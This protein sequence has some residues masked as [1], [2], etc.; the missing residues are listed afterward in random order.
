[1]FGIL[2]FS[3]VAALYG[4]LCVMLLTSWRGR[5]LGGFLI[6]ACF[7]STIW[8]LLL[9]ASAAD[10]SVPV[11]AIFVVEV[12]R[13]GA[14]LTFLGALVS[15]IGVSGRIGI[16]AHAVWITVLLAGLALWL[17]SDY[18]GPI[19][20]LGSVLIPGGLVIALVG[21]ILIEQLYRNSAPESR[22]NLI[23]VT[24]VDHVTRDGACFDDGWPADERVD[25]DAALQA[26]NDL[27]ATGR[28]DRFDP[29]AAGSEQSPRIVEDSE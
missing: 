7:V 18:F 17:G 2:S 21:L 12:L 15:R 27:L 3:L 9:A 6:A 10:A 16:L 23:Q 28:H 19:V 4:I 14:W 1:M 26:L 24:D 29:V 5:S 22:L 13:G 11:L 25:S 8:A 20:D